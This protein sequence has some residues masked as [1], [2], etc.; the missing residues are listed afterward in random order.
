MGNSISQKVIDGI[1]FTKDDKLVVP[2]HDAK[3]EIHSL[4]FIDEDG[5]KT[6]LKGGK[7]IG[8]FFMID[9][10]NVTKSKEIYLVEGFATGVSIHIA[11]NKP[12]AVT[13]DAGNIEHVLKNLKDSHPNKE[14]TIAADN[15]L[16]KE[17]NIGRE[18][19][20]L[21]AKKFGAK[22]ILPEFTIAHKDEMPTDFND[23]H[24][25]SGIHE[26]K[27]QLESHQIIREHHHDLQI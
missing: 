14:F 2:L 5:K 19:A 1:R 11:T 4:Q 26:V 12:V 10:G 27:R 17:S 18:K 6:F 7:K 23:L 13:F 21:A 8:N 25:L 24:K 22:V 15:D 20:E 16:W 3:G 9:A